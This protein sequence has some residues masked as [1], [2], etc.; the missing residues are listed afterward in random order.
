MNRYSTRDLR[1]A[2]FLWAQKELPVKFAGLDADS[3]NPG[4]FL[5]VFN[6]EA[7]E[8]VFSQL[9][10]RYNSE[11]ALIEPRSYD[12]KMNNLRDHLRKV[13]TKGR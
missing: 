9:Q 11:E 6:Y 12:Q 13:T 2:A 10:H 3:K 5:F 7:S 4:V 8:D 1:E